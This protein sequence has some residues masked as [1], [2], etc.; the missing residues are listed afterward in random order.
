[1][2]GNDKVFKKMGLVEYT[3]PVD[4]KVKTRPFSM[5]YGIVIW[6]GA[7]TTNAPVDDVAIGTIGFNN[8]GV[9]TANVYIY[10]PAGWKDTTQVVSGFFGV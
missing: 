6:S 10:G 5:H 4:S 7:S 1:M 2:S 3:D 9:S 8:D